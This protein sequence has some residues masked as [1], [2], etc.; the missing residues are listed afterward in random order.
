MSVL[1]AGTAAVTAARQAGTPL[2]GYHV[3]GCHAIL[4]PDYRPA[5]GATPPPPATLGQHSPPAKR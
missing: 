2:A 5:P 3:P 4:P 1:V